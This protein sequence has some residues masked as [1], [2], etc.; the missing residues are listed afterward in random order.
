MTGPVLPQTGTWRLEKG[1]DAWSNCDAYVDKIHV[2]PNKFNTVGTLGKYSDYD[3][4]LE[5]AA[6]GGINYDQFVS[7]K[8]FRNR[9]LWKS[10]MNKDSRWYRLSSDWVSSGSPGLARG[11]LEEPQADLVGHWQEAYFRFSESR[12][13][14]NIKIL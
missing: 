6:L 9:R 11:T 14:P 7:W 3:E 12:L 4:E 1:K 13:K 8:P 2:T 10:E 5:Y